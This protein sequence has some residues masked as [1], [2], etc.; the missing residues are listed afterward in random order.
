MRTI[1]IGGVAAGMS[2][3]TRLRRLDEQR[4]IVVFER[5][6]HVSFAN[7][8]LPYYVGGVIE[9][10][11]ALLLQTPASLAARF[12]L[13]VH[14]QHEVVAIDSAAKTVTVRD[15]ASGAERV[16]EFDDLVLAMGA[17]VTDGIPGEGVPVISLRSVEDVDAITEVLAGATAPRA[18]VAGGGFIGVEAVENLVT[19]GAHVTL[20]QRGAQVLSPLDPEMASPVHRALTDAGVDF[21]ARTTIERVDAGRVTL[22]DGTEVAADL[23][24]DARGVRPDVRIAAAAGVGLGPTGGIAVDDRHRTDVPGIWAAGDAVEKTDHLDGQATLVTMA[25]LA[26][27][28]GRAVA[29]DI[30]GVATIPATPALGTSIVGVL[31]VTVGL[32]GWSER[33]LV[34]AGH[35]HRVVHTHPF[36]HATYYP[37]AEQMAMKLLVDPETDLLLGAQLVGRAGVDKRLDVLAVAMAAGLTA[38]ALSQLELAYAPQYG[39]AKDAINMAGYVAENLATGTD[40]T[41]QWHEVDAARVAG[42]VVVDVRTNGEHEAGAIPGSILLPLD[43]LRERHGELPD[44]PLIV[45][46]KVGQRGHTA[47]R[48]LQQLGH[49]V[50]NLDGGWL[51]WSDGVD[52]D[53]REKG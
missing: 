50:R 53:L 27:R 48:I 23:V 12:A 7:C 47:S 42:A 24:V 20:V 39:S 2:A 29:D 30:A 3:A 40:R 46:C 45:H 38:S 26:N 18:V 8:G 17:T 21:R 34:A 49:D 52:A 22:S 31:G 4:E 35:A 44:A 19:R 16:E 9:D 5:G 28:H 25:G 13:E 41:I 14:V 11:S 1:I 33:R 15:L 37:G 51:T 32:V 6:S 43:D 36:S 10:R